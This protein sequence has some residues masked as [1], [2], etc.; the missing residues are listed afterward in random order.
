M[1]H[2]SYIS[3]MDDGIHFGVTGNYYIVFRDRK[4]VVELCIAIGK[5]ERSIY[6]NKRHQRWVARIKNK[7]QK[8]KLKE[9]RDE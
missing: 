2:L 9:I 4:K 1:T 6:Y 7:N 5:S 8:L 3:C